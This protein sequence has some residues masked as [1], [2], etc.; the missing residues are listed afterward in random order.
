MLG[1]ASCV[2]RTETQ[3]QRPAAAIVFVMA[4]ELAV[5][6]VSDFQQTKLRCLASVAPDI[7]AAENSCISVSRDVLCGYVFCVCVCS[8]CVHVRLV[9]ICYTLPLA[10]AGA[11]A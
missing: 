5:I 1:I 6:Y 2:D 11:A 4:R 7:S 3:Q 9:R 10:P 8:V